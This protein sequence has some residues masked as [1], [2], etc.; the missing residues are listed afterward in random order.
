MKKYII[1]TGWWCDGTGTHTHSKHQPQVDKETR[2]VDFFNLWYKSVSKFTNPE[3]IIVIDSNSPIKPDLSDKE[4]VTLFSLSKNYGAAVDGSS[5]GILSGWDRSILTSA[6]IAFLDDAEY[7]VYV[8][9]DCVLW[10]ENIIEDI[11]NGM[12]DKMIVLGNGKG[13]PQPLQQ[14]LIVIKREF[15]PVFLFT[16]MN[17]TTE[18][19][20]ISP[21]MR[22]FEKFKNHIKFLDIDYGRKRP[23]N[24]EDKQFYAQHL[25]TNELNQFKNKIEYGK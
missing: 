21:E 20:K 10:G 22:Y 18:E 23:I 11:I 9:Q 5:K 19:L 15:I 14:S 4:N 12:G 6:S 17:S 7:F 24:F 16:E 3:K 2:Q 25:N 8:E 1:G 13:T